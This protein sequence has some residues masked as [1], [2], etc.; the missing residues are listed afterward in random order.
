[1]D[2]NR[3]SEDLLVLKEKIG[4]LEAWRNTT[5][6]DLKEIREV[7]A[8]VKLLMTLSLGGGGLSIITLVITLARLVEK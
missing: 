2:A 7:I 1:M 3:V 5:E 4:S 6:A 8:Q